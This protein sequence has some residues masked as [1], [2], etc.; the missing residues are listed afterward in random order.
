MER[1]KLK[2]LNIIEAIKMPS[3]TEFKVLYDCGH[4][5]KR[6]IKKIPNGNFEWSDKKQESLHEGI[7]IATFIPIQQPVSFM[8]VVNSDKRCKVDFSNIGLLSHYNDRIEKFSCKTKAFGQI[9]FDLSNSFPTG[10]VRQIIQE[11]KWYIEES[12]D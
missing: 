8:E 4:Y 12:E 10:I 1:C 5:D 3:Y 2:K 7:L 11:G 6:T 9:L